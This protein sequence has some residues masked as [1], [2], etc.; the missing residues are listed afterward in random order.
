MV[1]LPLTT[2]EFHFNIT[3]FYCELII[4][5]KVIK[6]SLQNSTQFKLNCDDKNS[7]FCSS[8]KKIFY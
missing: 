6:K 8:H 4:L 2:A 1:K 3:N 7:R 5:P